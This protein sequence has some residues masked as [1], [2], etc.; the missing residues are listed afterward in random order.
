[1]VSALPQDKFSELDHKHR[2]YKIG[3]KLQ[4]RCGEDILEENQKYFIPYDQPNN[5]E[6]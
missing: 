4:C 5:Q 3:R 1:M 6:L 2:F